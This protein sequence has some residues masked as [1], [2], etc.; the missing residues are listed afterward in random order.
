MRRY[1]HCLGDRLLLMPPGSTQSSPFP[2]LGSTSPG[3]PAR[4]HF[5]R[6]DAQKQWARLS[7]RAFCQYTRK[8]FERA[9]GRVLDMSTVVPLLLF[10]SRPFFFLSSLSFLHCLPSLSLLFSSLLFSSLLSSLLFSSLLFSSLLFSSLLFS[11]LL[12]SSRLVSSLLF[13]F[14]PTNT[15]KS[16]EQRTRR[17]TLRRLNVMWR[18]ITSWKLPTNCTECFHLSPSLPL[19]PP[20]LLSL[21]R[22]KRHLYFFSKNPARQFYLHYSLKL[23]RKE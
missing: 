22:K 20:S 14:S 16:T 11:S 12:V 9:H 5:A 19:S 7:Q 8:R 18:T 15:E 6:G 21:P 1:S 4:V 2:P 23:I 3:L 17:P 13:L 10:F